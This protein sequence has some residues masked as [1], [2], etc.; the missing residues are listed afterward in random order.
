[1]PGV[2]IHPA[3]DPLC[4][5]I[6]TVAPH[7]DNPNRGDVAAITESVE[8]NGYYQ[9]VIVQRSTGR[10]LAGEHRW[11]ALRALGATEIPAVFLDVDDDAALRIML[12]DNHSNRLGHDD[13]AALLAL[14]DTLAATTGGLTGSTYTDADTADLN[15]LLTEV[16][17][18]DPDAD[19]ALNTR[20]EQ[21]TWPAVKLP[22][23]LLHRLRDLPGDV[24]ADK[25]ANALDAYD[26][27]GPNR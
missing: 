9:P 22:P 3:L 12:G 17:P 19:D 14:L 10:I 6:D 7:P 27:C 24:D 21:A 5:D 15:A 2:V 13:P 1:M 8:A 20:M 18:G 4:V 23:V 11:H 16:D 26:D 25:I